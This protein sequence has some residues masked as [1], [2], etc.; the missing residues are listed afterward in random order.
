MR[1]KSPNRTVQIA[2]SANHRRHSSRFA[3]IAGLY[4]S[5]AVLRF[6]EEHTMKT[7]LSAAIVA[8]VIAGAA[9]PAFAQGTPATPPAAPAPSTT[10]PA[11]APTPSTDASKP[12]V[13]KD[14]DG[15][16]VKP[17]GQ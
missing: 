17:A 13:E 2:L 3:E 7:I 16:P 6:N 10:T 5:I 4:Q 1:T 11:P 9:A 12:A 15:K 14:K 8:A